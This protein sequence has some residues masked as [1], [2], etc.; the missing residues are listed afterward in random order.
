MGFFSKHQEKLGR[1]CTITSIYVTIVCGMSSKEEDFQLRHSTNIG[2]KMRHIDYADKCTC[3]QGEEYQ[4]KTT[5][6]ED[7]LP[8]T[9]RGTSGHGPRLQPCWRSTNILAIFLHL[10]T[11]NSK[12]LCGRTQGAGSTRLSTGNFQF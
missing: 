11:G 5:A 3:C 9:T 10:L 4:P 6:L 12:Y 2:L 8:G 1:N 7:V